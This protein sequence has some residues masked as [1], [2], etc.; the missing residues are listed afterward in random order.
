MKGALPWFIRWAR[1]A[2]TRDFYPA[3][4]AQVS[5]VENIFPHRTL[6]QFMCPPSPSN[7]GRQSCWVACPCLRLKLLAGSGRKK[8]RD[9]RNA[10]FAN[11]PQNS[12]YTEE[13]KG[14]CS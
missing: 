12:T 10:I 13:K 2:G 8:V 1:R 5:P 11:I 9:S 6:F 7:L 3:Y 14:F 4:A